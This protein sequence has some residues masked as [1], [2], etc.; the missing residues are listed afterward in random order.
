VRDQF[1]DLGDDV[2]L[3][4]Y[5]FA[6]AVTVKSCVVTPL[7]LTTQFAFAA[8][9][10]AVALSKVGSCPSGYSSSGNYCTPSKSAHFAIEK[11]GSCP[12]GYL[13]SGAYCLAGNN[14]KHAV[15]KNGSCPNG[16]MTSG[17]YCLS[18]K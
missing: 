17:N 15:R 10:S 6:L 3:G 2:K 16:Y 18:T 1:F 14:V 4:Q 11:D 12:S 9:L 5:R 7:L 13:T 8:E